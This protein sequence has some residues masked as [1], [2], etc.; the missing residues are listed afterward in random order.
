MAVIDLRRAKYCCD[1]FVKTGGNK[2][3]NSEHLIQRVGLGFN[4]L[5]IF[6][7]RSPYVLMKN[8]RLSYLLLSISNFKLNIGSESF[9][10]CKQHNLKKGSE[11]WIH[12]LFLGNNVKD[13]IKSL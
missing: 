6:T 3:E 12:I 10:S 4:S 13:C 8:P 11:K 7:T 9:P 1:L 2:I 5:K